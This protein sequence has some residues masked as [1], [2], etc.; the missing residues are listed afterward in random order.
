M[1]LSDTSRLVLVLALVASACGTGRKSGGGRGAGTGGGSRDAGAVAAPG[2]GEGEGA[3]EGE[4]EGEGAAEGEGEGEGAAEGEGEGPAEGEGEGDPSA[5][6]VLSFDTNVDRL[7]AEESVTFTAV[8]TDPDGIDDL[9]GGS[10]QDPVS[11]ATY[12]AFAT[13]AGEGAYSTTLSW[14]DLHQVRAVTFVTETEREFEAVFFDVAGHRATSRLAVT[15]HCDGLG[16]CEGACT[17]LGTTRNCGA[18][19]NRCDAGGSSCTGGECRCPGGLTDCLGVC[20][21]TSTAAEHCGRCNNACPGAVGGE[22]RCEE[23]RCVD[24]CPGGQLACDGVCVHPAGDLG[25]CGACGNA[26]PSA[27][28][29]QA[30]CEDG[31]CVDPCGDRRACAGRCTDLDGDPQHCGACDASCESGLRRVVEAGGGQRRDGRPL[32]CT[33]ARCLVQAALGWASEDDREPTSCDAVC[34]TFG[35]GCADVVL[36]WPS[37]SALYGGNFGFPTQPAEGCAVYGYEDSPRRV[38]GW[39]QRCDS[40]IQPIFQSA[41]GPLLL[42]TVWCHCQGS[43]ALPF[44]AS[45]QHPTDP[46][47][48]C[49]GDGDGVVESP[50]VFGRV[51]VPDVTPGEGRGQGITAELGLGPPGSYPFDGPGWSWTAGE[52]NGDLLTEF[53]ELND[54]EYRAVLAEVPLGLHLLAWRF[55]IGAGGWFYADLGPGGSAD[56]FS[57]LST[58]TLL[59]LPDCG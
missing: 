12:G 38:S 55:R 46:I 49:D 43:F 56:G 59:A 29:G 9:I 11:G 42:N 53:G 25:H 35:L 37:C 34:G 7:T 19:G 1:S 8:V 24:P 33:G 40:V 44:Y 16:A 36:D 13:A 32:D 21:D 50:L 17:D 51:Y 31:Q 52:Y 54:D 14:G 30:R 3:A 39:F 41:D 27:V 57:P 15:L 4:G 18:C 26:C 22:P 58:L 10:L 47:S 6:H 2:V 5:P 28:G 48:V 20:L 23:G 45:I